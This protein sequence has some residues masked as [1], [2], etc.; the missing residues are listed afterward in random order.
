MKKRILTLA[1]LLTVGLSSIFANNEEKLNQ[2]AANSFKEEFSQAT[3]VR[4]ENSKEFSK[5]TFKLNDQVMFAYYSEI[6][7]LMAVTRNIVSGQLP[8]SLQSSLKKEY[9]SAWISDLFELAS[10]DE[11]S[12][13]VTLEST[14]Y[15]IVLKSTGTQGWSVFKKER[16]TAA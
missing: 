12:Y 11:T 9:K 14:E 15:T 2:K 4:W 6:G 8:I 7:K 5:V 10:D 13:Y 3:D 16:K 1:L